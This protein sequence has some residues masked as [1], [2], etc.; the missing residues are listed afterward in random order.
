MYVKA[1]SKDIKEDAMGRKKFGERYP[2]DS[3]CEKQKF[4]KGL[5]K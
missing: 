5:G 1:Q 2:K 3:T 4:K